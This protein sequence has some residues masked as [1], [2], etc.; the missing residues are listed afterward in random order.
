MKIAGFRF[1]LGIIHQ[2][3]GAGSLTA[4][5][6]WEL[7]PGELFLWLALGTLALFTASFAQVGISVSSAPPELPVYEQ[8]ICPGDGYLWTRGYWAWGDDAYHWESGDWEMQGRQSP[9]GGESRA[10]GVAGITN[11]SANVS[12]RAIQRQGI[13]K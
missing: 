3:L 6:A 10:A 13:R 12:R 4:P 7:A 9:G 11:M 5:S 1:G 2:D 8:P